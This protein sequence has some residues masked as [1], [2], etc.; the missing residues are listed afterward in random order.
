MKIG[1]VTL[2]GPGDRGWT[3]RQYHA[4]LSPAHDV[5]VLALGPAPPSGDGWDAA[6]V[7]HAPSPTSDTIRQW[8]T[9]QGLEAVLF[10]QCRDWSMVR[11]ARD[12]CPLYAHL[13]ASQLR[14]DELINYRAFKQVF[15]FSDL[16]FDY[17]EATG[18]PATRLPIGVVGEGWDDEAPLQRRG[19][20]LL[21]V[22]S[23]PKDAEENNTPA[24]LRIFERIV[25]GNPRVRLILLSRGPWSEYPRPWQVRAEHP[26]VHVQEGSLPQRAYI[27]LLLTC[28]MLIHPCRWSSTPLQ[29]A[30]ALRA[31]LPVLSTQAPPAT[32][33]VRHGCNGL[34]IPAHKAPRRGELLPAWEIDQDEASASLALLLSDTS[35]LLSMK[36]EAR[37][38][39]AERY[40]PNA[41]A[42]A[43]RR[44]FEGQ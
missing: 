3:A 33:H 14:A 5:S 10:N 6:P 18:V 35:L 15:S 31:G 42:E 38:E 22:L 17:L 37:Q 30:E 19:I 16:G 9:D 7:L 41:A 36:A 21:H 2:W 8:I 40:E 44:E 25:D 12:R 28:D 11:A 43:M 27:R 4:A 26:N 20:I 24:A 29:I 34:L 13:D 39:G 1:F 23:D 32:E